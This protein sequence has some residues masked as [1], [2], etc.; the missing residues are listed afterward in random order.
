[1]KKAIAVVF[2]WLFML[3]AAT[4]AAEA[5]A[6]TP[7]AL[8]KDKTQEI[9]ALLKQHQGEYRR[10]R[11]KLYDMVNKQ[12]LPYFDFERMSQWVLGRYWR[13]ANDAQRTQFV[14]EFRDLLVR[15][16]ATALLNYTDQQVMYMPFHM[17]PNANEAVVRTAIKQT[18][19]GPDVP[20]YYAFYKGPQGWKAYDVSI[21]GVSLVTNYRA[22]FASKIRREGIDGLLKSMA[23]MKA[24]PG[25]PGAKRG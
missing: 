7:D 9:M 5:P 18:S 25:A 19:G 22:T 16:Y 15:T 13:Q 24:A 23:Q 4:R 11:A 3:S 17:A 8:V 12:V 2:V 21:D 6:T 10:D 14:H 1:M 20:I